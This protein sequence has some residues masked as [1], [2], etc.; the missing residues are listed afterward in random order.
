MRL[1]SILL[2]TA[3][4]SAGAACAQAARPMTPDAWRA[5]LR[6]LDAQLQRRHANLF[7]TVTRERWSAEV[8]ALDAAI[9]QLGD[10][11]VI[12]RMKRLVALVGDGHT[13]LAVPGRVRV[14]PLGVQRF[15]DT[16]RV[17]RA[18]E[19]DRR[20]LGGVLVRVGEM[21]AVADLDHHP[22]PGAEVRLRVDV[23]RLARVPTGVD[24]DQ[25]LH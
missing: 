18:T 15:G 23:S 25:S 19:R 10:D 8:S 5:D 14:Y 24:G 12:A 22:G 17:V 6:F 9:P 4:L 13:G 20:A 7:H 2:W 3:T 11:E 16:L 1:P 21:D